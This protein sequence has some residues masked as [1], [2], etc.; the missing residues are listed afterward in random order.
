MKIL[1]FGNEYRNEFPTEVKTFFDSL[2]NAGAEIHF[3]RAFGEKLCQTWGLNLNNISLFSETQDA[4]IALSFGGDG[5]LLHT[6][7]MIREREIPIL[8]INFG[9]LGFLTDVNNNELENLAETLVSG[10]FE[11]DKRITLKTTTSDGRTFYSL[12]ELTVH[13][14]VISSIINIETRLNGEILNIYHADGLIVSTPTGSTAYSLSVGGPILMPNSHNLIIAPVASH[15]LNDRPIVIPDDSVIELS[16]SSRNG[17]YLLSNDNESAMMSCT[18]TLRM[19]RAPF[20]VR[21]IRM[22]GHSFI[23]TLKERLYWG[24]DNRS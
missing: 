17:K 18:T 20:S 2:R 11:T 10:C 23:Q 12:N 4:D 8:G 13:K 5:T 24:I 19:E 15:S 6:A 14:Q 21:I 3:E 16:I 9:H 7:G 22:S 1:V